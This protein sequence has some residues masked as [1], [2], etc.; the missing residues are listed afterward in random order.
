MRPE[1]LLFPL[2]AAL[3]LAACQATEP[4]F[5]ERVRAEGGRLAAMGEDWTRGERMIREGREL[6]ERG[7]DLIA[8]GR[9]DTRRGEKM[10]REGRELQREAEAAYVRQ[11]AG[12]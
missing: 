11:A 4:T 12:S 8:K 10:I 1:R 7:E 9:R 2:A 3:A 6:V 5:G